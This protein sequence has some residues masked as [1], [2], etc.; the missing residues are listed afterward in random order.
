MRE[1][2]SVH[3]GQAGVQMG[4]AIWELFC[5][6]H[7]INKD[8]RPAAK[9]DMAA[10]FTCD[11][12]LNTFF[13]ETAKDKLVP[14]AIF[15]DLEPSVIDPIRT[16]PFKNLF[17]R[18]WLL[19]GSED[20]ANNF[21]RGFRTVGAE[22]MGQLVD[23]I[24]QLAESS[25]SLQGFIVY[26]SFGGGTG[27]GLT[28]L[29]L[30]ELAA[31][32]DRKSKYQFSVYPAPTVSTSVV[33]PY[34]ALLTTHFS[35]ANSNCGFLVDNEAIYD[36]CRKKLDID[37]PHYTNLNQLVS[38]IVSSMTASMRCGGALNVDLCEF[39]TNLVPF[40]R[41]HF[42]LVSYAPIVSQECPF[43][44][45]ITTQDITAACFAPDH[46]LVKCNQ[47]SGKYM[48][49]CMLYRGDVVPSD[50]ND[51]IARVKTLH[52]VQ[53]VNWC[54][55]GFKVGINCQP[56]TRIPGAD[57]AKVNRA[58]CIL[59]NTTAIVEAW[60]RLSPKFS[61]MYAKKAF[62]HWFLGEGMEESEFLDAQDDMYTLEADYRLLNGSENEMEDEI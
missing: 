55:T 31:E 50:V 39:Q 40:P 8:G 21:A 34:N 44:Q 58:L 61:I 32:F 35:L 26:H 48:A 33:E 45:N 3:V 9:V 23:K 20:A 46:Q 13:Q 37:H 17:N 47:S 6:E 60:E 14:R 7:Q 42:P 2:V 25:N 59:C 16:G 18:S 4:N 27:S 52:S 28:A 38:Q 1:C 41:I 57:F 19:T 54:P 30:E 49:C 53:F 56:P 24:R 43:H 51:A 5:L 36:I 29:L 11:T 12:V 10:P 22:K 62:V 15:V